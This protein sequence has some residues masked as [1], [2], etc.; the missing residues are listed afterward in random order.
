M[1]SN[2][3]PSHNHNLQKFPTQ[4]C[5]QGHDTCYNIAYQNHHIFPWA[6]QLTCEHCHFTWFLCTECHSKSRVIIHDEKQLRRHG[7]NA[8]FLGWHS[9]ISTSPTI[10]VPTSTFLTVPLPTPCDTDDTEIDTSTPNDFVTFEEQDQ[11]I[12]DSYSQSSHSLEDDQVV[13]DIPVGNV[14]NFDMVTT[15]S[16]NES[17]LYFS[18]QLEN[19]Q[20]IPYLS[21]RSQFGPQR[22]PIE[23]LDPEEVMLRAIT[24]R[25]AFQQTASQNALL[26]SII[27]GV[28]SVV[29]KRFQ[30]PNTSTASKKTIELLSAEGSIRSSVFR[31]GD[32]FLKILPHPAVSVHH[33]HA[34]CLPSDCI[35]DLRAH[36]LRSVLYEPGIHEEG[37]FPICG[38]RETAFMHDLFPIKNTLEAIIDG[39]VV[40][41]RL[42][43]RTFN[44]FTD[45]A[46][47]NNSN[48]ASSHTSDVW[49]CIIDLSTHSDDSND[50]RFVYPVATGPKTS[51]HSEVLE[52]LARDMANLAKP[53]LYY[54][55]GHHTFVAEVSRMFVSMQDQI[56]PL[57]WQFHLSFKIWSFLRLF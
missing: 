10:N 15:F 42:R 3:P 35:A 20:G 26:E 51:N 27:Q 16:R 54:D 22:I 40:Q 24:A 36:G 25:L 5:P 29:L 1:T 31:G 52:I 2:V 38:R 44:E 33:D 50:I 30:N 56:E 39:Q 45:D 6:L 41:V 7:Y 14:H 21:S 46:N 57:C 23:Q 9:Q 19:Q 49:V 47:V 4:T 17:K 11:E 34:Y 8:K 48:K 43:C 53:G 18:R 13:D 55:G 37:T 28:E 12:F 32:S